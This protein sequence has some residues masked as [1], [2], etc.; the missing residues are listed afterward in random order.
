MCGDVP[1][2]VEQ[3]EFPFTELMGVCGAGSPSAEAEAAAGTDSPDALSLQAQGVPGPVP[4][5]TEQFR[6][7]GSQVDVWHVGT[8]GPVP[9]SPAPWAQLFEQCSVP[10]LWSVNDS[11]FVTCSW[12]QA[13]PST[14][15][16]RN[17]QKY[18][19][20]GGGI[21]MGL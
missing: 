11:L 19:K 5:G 4:L 12:G 21:V 10:W 7:G 6:N 2:Q 3:L 1:A 9:L 18:R 17:I 8:Q 16:S 13:L 15:H 20:G 14:C